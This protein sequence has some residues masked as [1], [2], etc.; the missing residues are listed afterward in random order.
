MIIC[1]SYQQKLKLKL[2][3]VYRDVLYSPTRHLEEDVSVSSMFIALDSVW[4]ELHVAFME[5]C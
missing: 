3:D 5:C 4:S 2:F 1:D